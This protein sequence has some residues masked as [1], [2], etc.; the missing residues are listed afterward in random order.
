MDGRSEAAVTPASR[1]PRNQDFGP[2]VRST[3]VRFR[4]WA[5]REK[6]VE[7][8]IRGHEVRYPMKP[9]AAGWHQAEVPA[10]PGDRYAFA[11]EDGTV[12]P[13][14]ASRSQPDDVHGW[15]EIVAP[16]YVWQC[17]WQGRR[18]EELVIYEL[19]IGTFTPEG[20]FRAAIEKLDHLAGLGVTAIEI[21][22]VADFPGRRNWG[23]DGTFLYAP[24]ASYGRPDDLRALVDAAHERGIAVL[25]DVVYNHFGP[26]GN[27]L[28]RLAP[29]FFTSRHQTPWGAAVNLDG[30]GSGIVREF[31]IQNALYWLNAFRL[32]GL[33]LD[34]V[35]ALLDESPQHFLDELASRV[36]ATISRPVHLVLENEENQARHLR[37]DAN[38]AVRAYDAQ[39][40]DDV[41]HALHVAL[42]RER[43]G[44]YE[45][46]CDDPHLLARSLAEGFAFQ[47]EVMKFRGR[48]RGERSAAL[49][50]SAFVSFLQ[51]HDQV[52][53]RAFGERI[54]HL[55]PELALRAAS[56]VFL[57][58]PQIPMLF[59]GEEWRARQPFQFFC[60]FAGTLGEQ[61]RKGRREE[62]RRFPEFANADTRAR[63]PDPQ[64]EKTFQAS[65]LDWNDR[66]L[67]EH[68]EWL[69]W[70]TRILAVR[71]ARIVPL[72]PA[73]AEGGL[74]RVVANG[75]VFVS[76]S[77]GDGRLLRVLANLSAE[78]HEF[79]FD[80]AP[81]IWHEGAKP[82]WSLL[83]P[84]SVRW[85][86]TDRS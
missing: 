20:T 14:P 28:P 61:V 82:E 10:K 84:W 66:A 36:R 39:W 67:P 18:W 51:N 15:S 37:R 34:A 41:H 73:I 69:R 72:I 53:N 43:S 35:H 7:L 64:S 59:M 16:N 78:P 45:E 21:M 58:A 80:D 71:R 27:Y 76:W 31:F 47:G 60:D 46:Y 19:H 30:P 8:C 25:L 63:I 85:T 86:L 52:G 32:D 62:F 12:V 26:D 24:D 40:N 4:L 22:P 57:L 56:A 55:A 9:L 5:P 70:Y 50:P 1:N 81:V 23:Y 11:L 29:P 68:A 54:C 75:A 77:C 33:R 3:S 13:D 2:L 79:P 6:R 49:P 83:A 42:T 74:A 38:G 48:K 17:D 65:K 44:Y